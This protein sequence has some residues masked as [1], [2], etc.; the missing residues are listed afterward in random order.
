MIIRTSN[1]GYSVSFYEVDTNLRV[2]KIKEIE[3]ENI[4]CTRT[5]STKI[6]Q[7]KKVIEEKGYIFN[8]ELIDEDITDVT[9][10]VIN[11]K[12]DYYAHTGNY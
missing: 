5:D 11:G 12:V 9:E 2:E 6:E 8:F 10:Y 3:H 7:L 4:S 1:L